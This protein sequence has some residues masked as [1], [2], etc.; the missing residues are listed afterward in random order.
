MTGENAKLRKV[1]GDAGV[2]PNRVLE[3]PDENTQVES[4][5][6][7]ELFCKAVNAELAKWQDNAREYPLELVSYSRRSKKMEEWCKANSMKCPDKTAVAAQVLSL[8]SKSNEDTS[9]FALLDKT[10]KKKV[11]VMLRKAGSLLDVSLDS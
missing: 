7:P 6:S 9:R 8:V 10:K 11:V 1:L 2:S 4:F 5:I 3:Y